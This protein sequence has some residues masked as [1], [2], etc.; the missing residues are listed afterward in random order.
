[1]P[2]VAARLLEHVVEA[3][4]FE[5]R[6]RLLL[7]GEQD[8]DGVEHGAEFVA[9]APDQE[10]VG[11]RER[12]LGA[13]LVRDVHRLDAGRLRRRRV[14]HIAFDVEDRRRGNLVLVEVCDRELAR[15]AQI[16]AHAALVVRRHRDRRRA[17]WTGRW[18]RAVS[19][20]AR[21]Y[22]SCWRGTLRP[23]GPASPCRNRRRRRPAR[24]SPPWCW[25]PSRPRSRACCRSA[26]CSA[27][28]RCS[29]IRVIVPL[30]M[31]WSSRNCLAHRR[32]HVDDRIAESGH[33]KF[34][35]HLGFPPFRL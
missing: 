13:G 20:S 19:C 4:G 27:A 16:G 30:A 34:P 28:A 2:L 9:I 7:V 10:R 1:M 21:R 32:Q 29:S 22:P 6:L 15:R 35:R 11:H 17:R 8:V 26:A 14:P 18:S 5:Q 33:L 24:R 23:A 12:D 31:L 3:V 25:R